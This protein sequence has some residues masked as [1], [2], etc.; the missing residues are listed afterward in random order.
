M[1]VDS[2]KEP[3]LAHGVQQ[4]AANVRFLRFGV[5]NPEGTVISWRETVLSLVN[6]TPGPGCYDSL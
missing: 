6:R 4:E 3:R 1:P 5:V 2:L